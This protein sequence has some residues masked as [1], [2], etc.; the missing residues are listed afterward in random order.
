VTGGRI[1]TSSS[2]RRVELDGANS[3][4][5]I[6]NTSGTVAAYILGGTSFGEF[7]GVN[8]GSMSVGTGVS[9]GN[10]TSD[11]LSAYGDGV[12]LRVADTTTAAAN[13]RRPSSS[14]NLAVFTSDA[15]VKHDI[16]NLT[17]GL[18]VV[19]S[20]NPVTFKS[21]VDSTDKTFSGFIAQEVQA[22][23]PSETYTIVSE[24]EGTIPKV[25]GADPD[26]YRENPL[27][28]LNSI[29][30]LPY[31]TKAIQQLSAKVDELEAKIAEAGI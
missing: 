23:L 6:Y 7:T 24:E 30:L 14:T 5:N 9:L 16:T 22:I 31:L 18:N 21:L 3:R 20:L 26:D 17:D 28:S 4:L 1:R 13:L 10:T 15:R 2:G 12:I 29:E 19:C 11:S 8:G 25:E 27:L